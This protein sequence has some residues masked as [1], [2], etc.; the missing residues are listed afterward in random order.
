MLAHIIV[1]LMR[2]LP[3]SWVSSYT[4][5]VVETSWYFMA[6]TFV[7]ALKLP[8]CFSATFANLSFKLSAGKSLG[9]Y[10]AV[11]LL[12]HAIPIVLTP[13]GSCLK[14]WLEM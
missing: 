6:T 12:T 5:K 4:K 14:T 13:L 9:L 8:I 11:V 3:K 7:S 1:A 10:H 2:R